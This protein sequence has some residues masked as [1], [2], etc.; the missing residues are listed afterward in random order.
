M[1]LHWYVL[2]GEFPPMHGGVGAHSAHLTEALRAAGQTSEALVPAAWD[3]DGLAALDERLDRHSGAR[4]IIVQYTP[5]NFGSRFGNPGAM[6]WLARRRAAGDRVWTMVHEPFYPF[7]FP[8]RPQRWALATAHRFAL[9]LALRASEHVFVSIPAWAHAVAGYMSKDQPVT[10]LPIFSNIAVAASAP[11]AS[12]RSAVEARGGLLLGCFGALT[13]GTR[14]FL[15]PV[16]PRIMGNRH[17]LLLMGQGAELLRDALA[18]ADPALAE[19]LYCPGHIADQ[20][21][22]ANLMAVDLMVQEYPDGVSSRRGGC[23]AA[24]AHGCAVLTT[25]G[26]LTEPLWHERACVSLV[27]ARD[28]AA[29]IARAQTLLQSAEARRALGMRAQ[30]V[31]RELFAVERTV[32]SLL[33][34]AAYAAPARSQ[35]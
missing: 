3:A 29:L 6:R 20:E 24:L 31:Y 25:S 32:D 33:K 34:T 21:I 22:S 15:L 30:A 28:G 5:M 13:H 16:L 19:R 26:R 11:A 23:M 2:T 8:D 7:E 17:S 1:N 9:W 14:A 27:E 4:I 12:L 18:S 10:W 35:P